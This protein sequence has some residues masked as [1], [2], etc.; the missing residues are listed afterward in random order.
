MAPGPPVDLGGHH[1][2]FSEL[3]S[4]L[5][6]IGQLAS[7]PVLCQPLGT[8]INTLKAQREA[9]KARKWKRGR[10]RNTKKREKVQ[11]MKEGEMAEL[12]ERRERSEAERRELIRGAGAGVSTDKLVGKRRRKH[13]DKTTLLNISISFQLP[14]PPFP[15]FI[16][17]FFA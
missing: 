11:T 15:K 16:L 17:W 3:D 13:A 1:S 7:L 8:D 10:G 12:A 5:A 9:L 4:L 14:P 2:P 6:A